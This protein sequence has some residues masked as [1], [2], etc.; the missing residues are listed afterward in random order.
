V[1]VAFFFDCL[2]PNTTG[3][4]EKV[5][6]R[7]A[8]GFLEAGHDATYFTRKQWD[9]SDQIEDNGLRIEAL[10]GPRDLYY[11]DGVRKPSTAVAFAAAIFFRLLR[12]RR[13]FDAVFVSATP[14]LNVLAARLALLGRGIPLCVDYME[15]WSKKQSMEYSGPVVGSIAYFLQSLSLR[16]TSLATV[17]SRLMA[18]RVTEGGFRGSIIKTPGLIPK[19]PG[20]TARVTADRGHEPYILFVGRHIQDK[21]TEAIPPAL[22]VARE[23]YPSLRAV[24]LGE[25]PETERISKAV[26]AAGLES[27][28]T[29][30]GFVGGA[31]LGEY[32]R[33]AECLVNPSRRE[34]YGL[35]IVEA[36]GYGT[37]SVVTEHPNNAAVEL[38]EVGVNGFIAP[39]DSPTD[40]GGAIV[41]V[42]DG[43]QGLRATTREW[44]DVVVQDRSLDRT[45]EHLVAEFEARVTSPRQRPAR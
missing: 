39:S 44:Y 34:G 17:H 41:A 25:G 6:R 2:Y 22:K 18:T 33:H 26:V 9:G 29:L 40:L 45:A 38:V 37:P 7:L 16:V 36:A 24:I 5:Y 43:G 14:V 10:T 21:R 31:E 28:V 23:S 35:V 11:A 12:S 30:P 1:H 20:V 3:G 42:L 8:E 19:M 32:M 13:R 27:A 15:V 4:A